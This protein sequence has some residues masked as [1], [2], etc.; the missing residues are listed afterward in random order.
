[1]PL[2]HAQT[3]CVDALAGGRFKLAAKAVKSF[4]CIGLRPPT[5]TRRITA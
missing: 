3:P 1:M 5:L 2:I 4:G